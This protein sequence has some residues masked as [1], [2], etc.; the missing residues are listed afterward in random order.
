M[1]NEIDVTMLMMIG[2]EWAVRLSN[3]IRPK[4]MF[5]GRDA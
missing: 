1:R 4:A 2:P 3:A 5:A